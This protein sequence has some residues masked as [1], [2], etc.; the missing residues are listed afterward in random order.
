MV[1]PLYVAASKISDISLVPRPR[2]SIVADE[3]VQNHE[4][5]NEKDKVSEY[6]THCLPE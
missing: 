6:H 1:S 2:D 3:D 5:E 4:N